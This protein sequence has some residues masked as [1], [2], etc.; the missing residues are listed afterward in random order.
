MNR[1]VPCDGLTMRLLIL[2]RMNDYDEN[3]NKQ[4]NEKRTE[5]QNSFPDL[6]VDFLFGVDNEDGIQDGQSSVFD[7]LDE[8][9]VSRMYEIVE[10]I[11]EGGE[12]DSSKP[13]KC[14]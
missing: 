13:R 1:F 14:R 5:V 9:N 6:K 12:V 11:E 2:A 8:S 7:V 4:K 3:E 10:S